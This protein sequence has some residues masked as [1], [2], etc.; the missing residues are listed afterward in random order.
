MGISTKLPP[1]VQGLGAS[2]CKTE[3]YKRHVLADSV[4]NLIHQRTI[5]VE[6]FVVLDFHPSLPNARLQSHVPKP[7]TIQEKRSAETRP[8]KRAPSTPRRF[9]FTE[10]I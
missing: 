7:C 4:I 2:D 8:V 10:C 3:L 6:R 9:Y 1:Y 5:A